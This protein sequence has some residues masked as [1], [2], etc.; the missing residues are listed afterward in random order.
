MIINIVYTNNVY[1]QTYRNEDD[2]IAGC[3]LPM[4]LEKAALFR[5]HIH[6]VILE[7]F[8]NREYYA[9]HIIN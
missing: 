2:A 3:I 1:L 9:I 8:A 4:N 7:E 5:T 6:E